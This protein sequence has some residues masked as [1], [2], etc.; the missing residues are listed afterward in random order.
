MHSTTLFF[1]RSI[2]GDSPKTPFH[3]PPMVED[4]Q[5]IDFNLESL[6]TLSPGP[7]SPTHAH[8]T[9]L[10]DSEDDLGTSF[11]GL[12]IPLAD[13]IVIKSKEADLALR[14]VRRKVNRQR[15]DAFN[16]RQTNKH[17][18]AKK[19]AV[20]KS[21]GVTKTKKKNGRSGWRERIA[22]WGAF[23]KT[24]QQQKWHKYDKIDRKVLDETWANPFV[25]GAKPQ[26]LWVCPHLLEGRLEDG[27]VGPVSEFTI[28]EPERWKTALNIAILENPSK[29]TEG[30]EQESGKVKTRAEAAKTKPTDLVMDGK[31][32]GLIRTVTAL[33]HY[34]GFVPKEK[35]GQD[36]KRKRRRPERGGKNSDWR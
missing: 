5:S 24:A 20:A 22:K 21:K 34:I 15:A 4:Q 9:I 26:P 30:Q 17:T 16:K 6:E 32:C 18:L 23:L 29:E 35:K 8:G 13:A 28:L 31:T 7:A 10:P 1:C 27:T 2:L 11:E 33:I 19:N 25:D 36:D 14:L 12:K 3:A